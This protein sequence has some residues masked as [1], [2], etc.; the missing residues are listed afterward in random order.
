MAEPNATQPSLM[1]RI[2]DTDDGDAWR[3]FVSIYAPLVYGLARRHGLQDA[4][5][6]DLTQEVLRSVAGAAARFDYD[7]S[8]GSFRGWLYTIARNEIRD[9]L[10]RRG[11][12][13]IGR[14]DTEARRLLEALPT[15]EEDEEQRWRL[16]HE[17]R[18]LAW[19]ADRVRDQFEPSTW[20]AFRMTAQEGRPP[21]EVAETL[22]ISVGAVYIARSRV[23]A[24]LRD[25]IRD[26]EGD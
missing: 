17:R 25:V 26:L 20:L 8:R 24:R 3:Q 7:P 2:R 6:A 16:D 11:R 22:G 12:Q 5:A 10:G 18:V 21:R 1:A 15:P 4:D 23:L 13:P 9:H 14:G 19:A